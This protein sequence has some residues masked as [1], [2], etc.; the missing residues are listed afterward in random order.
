MSGYNQAHSIISLHNIHSRAPTVPL[1]KSFRLL[2]PALWQP[3]LIKHSSVYMVT[4]HNTSSADKKYTVYISVVFS[5]RSR[6]LPFS[7]FLSLRIMQNQWQFKVS[8][9]YSI[10]SIVGLCC[11]MPMYIP[12]CTAAVSTT[13][14]CVTFCVCS[15]CVCVRA[16]IHV[17]SV[18]I[19]LVFHC[20]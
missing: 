8:P 16:H 11:F 3:V 7:L 19:R 15:L 4:A 14:D 2:F 1:S 18:P 17:S 6:P 13:S 10:E 9:L 5:L 20:K 12:F